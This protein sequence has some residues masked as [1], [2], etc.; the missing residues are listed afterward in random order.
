MRLKS[1]LHV[2]ARLLP[3]AGGIVPPSAAVGKKLKGDNTTEGAPV[4]MCA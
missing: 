2:V 4:P 1:A 3:R